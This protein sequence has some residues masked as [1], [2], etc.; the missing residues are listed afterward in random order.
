MDDEAALARRKL[1]Y[2]ALARNIVAWSAYFYLTRVMGIDFESIRQ[3][4]LAG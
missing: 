1:I 3:A 4:K 2:W